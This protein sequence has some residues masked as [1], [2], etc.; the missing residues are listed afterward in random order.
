MSETGRRGWRLVVVAVAAFAVVPVGLVAVSILTPSTEVW[1]FLWRTDLPDMLM[2]TV[3]LLVAVVGCTL[4]LGAGLAWLVGRYRF[5][6]QRWFSWL[7][8][9][10]LAVPAYV[11]GFVYL[12]LLDYPGPVQSGLRTL[13][14]DNVWFPE[15]RTLP[16]AVLVLSLALYPYVYLLA[17]AALT[18]QTAATYEAARVLGQGPLQAAR[19]VV[20]PMARP[21][22]AAGAALVA[23]ETLTDFAT[24]Q[25]FNVQTVSVAVYQ[26]WNGMYDRVAASEIASLVLLFAIAVIGLERVARGRARFHQ[27]GG[28]RTVDP[29]HLSGTKAWAATGICG[30]VVAVTFVVPV[31]QL[32]A[33]SS[34]A[35]VLSSTGGLDPRY[36]GYLFN[37][38]TIATLTALA[39]A[40]IAV[41]VA[42]A[43]RLGGGTSTRRLARLATVG[44]AVPGPVVAIGVLAMLAAADAALDLVG[45][46]WGAVLVTGTLVGL[47]YAYIVRFLALAYTSVDASLEKVAPSITDAAL[48]LGAAPRGVVRRVH[49]PLV[50]SGVGVAL[51]LVA[52][53][54]LK[55]LPV[56][57]L[58]RPFGFETLAI[59][60]YQL[61]SES[62]WELAGLPALT[63][64]AVAVVP[65]VWLFRQTLQLASQ[66]PPETVREGPD[67]H[68]VR[69]GERGQS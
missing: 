60:V 58:L 50:R 28:A 14:G 6:G 68:L 52:V 9:L 65:V 11:L 47:L 39:C 29:V 25:Y 62:R 64:V 63:I 32:L 56:V 17:R 46:S 24:V 31:L 13:F 35:T 37:S 69:G 61:A 55:E 26:V 23:M 57:L 2:T 54:A 41:L 43:T 36:L 7:L 20:L 59:W 66:L 16:M 18:E 34:T 40:T 27:G 53:D 38:L 3:V 5:P 67:E 21:S 22:L 33:W 48:T 19:R 1:S 42:S 30:L 15:V 49:V 4:L 8:V 51:V 45:L 44:Y 10:P 12:G